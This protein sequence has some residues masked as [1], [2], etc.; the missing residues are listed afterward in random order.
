MYLYF[1]DYI[2]SQNN[3]NQ[4]NIMLQ[5]TNKSINYGF[6][7]VGLCG[8]QLEERMFIE[9]YRKFESYKTSSLFVKIVV[10]Y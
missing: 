3:Y 5:L 4:R 1:K 9:H 2:R 7:I 8:F 10:G 6:D